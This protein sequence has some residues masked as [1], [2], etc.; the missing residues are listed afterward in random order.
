MPDLR[1]QGF[2]ESVG[3][4]T[5]PN[6]MKKNRDL[7]GFHLFLVDV[8]AFCAQD[9]QGF[10][11]QMKCAQGMMKAGVNGPGIHQLRQAKLP[12]MP[13]ALEKR[14]FKEI[15]N[16]FALHR[17]KPVDGIVYDLIFVHGAWRNGPT[18]S[19]FIVTL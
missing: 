18:D 17:D 1:Q 9:I 13:H 14:M 2:F 19:A 3:E 7:G 4:G 8:N 15:E 10:S 12:D 6:V 11:H 16:R 5:M